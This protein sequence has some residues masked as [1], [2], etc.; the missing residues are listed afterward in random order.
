MS[1][2]ASWVFII[3]VAGFAL[4]LWLHFDAKAWKDKY[5]P[6]RKRR[7]RIDTELDDLRRL[8]EWR[9][10]LERQQKN[11]R[12]GHKDRRNNGKESK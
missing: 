3:T 9:A 5:E 10:A 4:G 12:I 7:D 1:P 11:I 2:L 6:N 8:E